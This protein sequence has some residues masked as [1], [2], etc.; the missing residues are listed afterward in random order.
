MNKFFISALLITSTTIFSQELDQAYLESLPEEIR[1]DV[2]SKIDQRETD[3]KPVYRRQSTMT[4]KPF[5]ENELEARKLRNRF[6]DDIFDMMQSTFMPINEPNLDSAYILDFG[7][8]L[9]IQLIGQ[10]N[11]IDNLSIKRDGSIN[12]PEIGKIFVS[13]LSL[14]DEGYR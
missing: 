2:L 10:K 12:I 14:D 7:D 13:G 3:E 11:S 1:K 9:E 8:T 4:D 6:G 5:S